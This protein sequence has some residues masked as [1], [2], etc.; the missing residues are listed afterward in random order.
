MDDRHLERRHD[1]Y[2]SQLEVQGE[3]ARGMN[4]RNFM[5]AAAGAVAAGAMLR[6]TGA[7][8]A[9]E[10]FAARFE[11]LTQT[12]PL[13]IIGTGVSVQD[14]YFQKFKEVSGFDVTGTAS[15]L[16]ESV[17]RFVTGGNETF[18]MIESNSFRAP[19]LKEADAAAPVPIEKITN[20]KYADAL[21]T[22]PANAGG[23][24]KSGWPTKA[25]F[26]DDKKDS[27]LMVPQIYNTDAMGILPHKFAANQKDNAI[28]DT[29]AVLYEAKWRDLDFKG[30]TAIQNDDLIGP[31]RA[32]TYHVKNGK[33]DAPKVSLSD[34][35]P[36]EIDE[37]I[38]F[39]IGAKRDG[40]F[41]L[42]WTNYGEAVNLLTSE[43][44]WAIDCW[45]PV[46]ED[47]KSQGVPCFYVDVW[48]GTS[49]W[50]YGM[51][52]SNKAADPEIVMAYMDWCLEGWRGSVD[53]TQGYYSP[54]SATTKNYLSPEAWRHW[55]EG[56]GR[57]TGPRERRFANVAFWNIW[58]E[59]VSDYIR[60]WNRFI[61][62]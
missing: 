49:A 53:A 8:K 56:D 18:G 13:N 35:Q 15:S 11:G 40:V 22:D 39:L 44:V 7:A 37:V 59:N 58:P 2:M 30:K 45:N 34:L 43:E 3:R 19:A 46:V 36:D 27:F 42:I 54:A 20:W 17:Q 60:G 48:E 9:A 41:R 32:A 57:D 1:N 55:Y 5:T 14:R 25:V 47:V 26:W 28:P 23:D 24:P 31:P 61:A 29:L 38:E 6:S 10:G 12:T 52:M 16:S 33:M 4:R 50:Y 21:F 62:A 51:T